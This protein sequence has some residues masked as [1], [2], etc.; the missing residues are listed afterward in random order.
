M[1]SPAGTQAAL[2]RPLRT[3][4]GGT[5]PIGTAP[6]WT[7]PSDTHA[8]QIRSA[9]PRAPESR[10]A[11]ARLGRRVLFVAGLLLGLAAIRPALAQS[12]AV[13][14]ANAGTV[15][16]VSG[17]VNGTYVRVAADLAAVL[18]DGDR[19]RVLPII[20]KG[21][22]Q[23]IADI[24]YLRGID[25]GIVQS[26]VLAYVRQQRLFPGVDQAIQYITKLY[27]EEVHVLARKDVGRLEDLS[28]QVVN[29][30]GKGSGS[31]M[32]ASVLF[33]A[34]GVQPKFANDDQD[35]AREA[36]AR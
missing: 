34:L 32:T 8:A 23:N 33:G 21:S 5:R 35:V 4:S 10:S 1:T 2:V 11:A 17:G 24:L 30:D 26:D 22:V 25:I 3:R 20:S 27:E 29:V 9:Q 13:T 14:A 28:G 36:E 16:V 12:D 6:P 18:D 31:A 7:R 19:L 15:G